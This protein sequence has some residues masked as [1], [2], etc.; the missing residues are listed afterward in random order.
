MHASA[1]S[2][3]ISF[4]TDSLIPFFHPLILHALVSGKQA[5][6]I[7]VIHARA[8][9]TVDGFPGQPTHTHRRLIERGQAVIDNRTATLWS[10]SGEDD[11]CGDN[12]CPKTRND[13]ISI[14]KDVYRPPMRTPSSIPPICVV[15]PTEDDSSSSSG[16]DTD[17]DDGYTSE[18]SMTSVSST[19]SVYSKTKPSSIFS[20]ATTSISRTTP[21]TTYLYQGGKTNVVTGGVMLSSQP[22]AKS[23]VGS[24]MRPSP[25]AINNP[26]S[27]WRKSPFPKTRRTA[28]GPDSGNWRKRA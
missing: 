16:S 15:I 19:R 20:S 10:K 4:L 13:S 22:P 14:K 27:S 6:Q 7:S 18:E 21:V 3:I 24:P 2:A 12:V 5:A 25:P 1:V 23:A 11:L 17:S 26:S 28:V 8:I 9:R